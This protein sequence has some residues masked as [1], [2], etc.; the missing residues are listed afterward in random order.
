M[1]LNFRIIKKKIDSEFLPEDFNSLL[2]DDY[3]EIINMKCLHCNFEED[4]ELILF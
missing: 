2:N 3:Y 4:M 1:K